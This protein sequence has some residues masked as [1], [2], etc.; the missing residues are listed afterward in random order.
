MCLHSIICLILRC[1]RKGYPGLYTD[2]HHYMTSGWLTEIL[3]DAE[4]CPPPPEAKEDIVVGKET[5]T[6]ATST[7][8]ELSE[9]DANSYSDALLVIGGSGYSFGRK[10]CYRNPYH[11][12]KLN[13]TCQVELWST[14]EVCSRALPDLPN[15]RTNLDAATLDGQPI[16]CGGDNTPYSCMKMNPDFTWSQFIFT[17]GIH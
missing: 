11:L 4:T 3:R 1:A 5:T 14:N 10:V 8:P 12:R 9:N 6:M 16:V 2:V 7:T 17:K 13:T 15:L